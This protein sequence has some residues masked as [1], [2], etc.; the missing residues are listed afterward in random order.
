MFIKVDNILFQD[1]AKILF[2][3]FWIQFDFYGFLEQNIYMYCQAQRNSSF[4]LDDLALFSLSSA[5]LI[6]LSQIHMHGLHYIVY[7]LH[8][9][10]AYGIYLGDH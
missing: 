6:S 5:Q 2:N 9:I 3:E 8:S 10:W 7:G 1:V 4:S